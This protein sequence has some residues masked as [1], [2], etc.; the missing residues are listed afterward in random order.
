MKMKEITYLT[1][2]RCLADAW[3]I[4]QNKN[5]LRTSDRCLPDVYSRTSGRPSS[6]VNFTIGLGVRSW[7]TVNFPVQLRVRRQHFGNLQTQCKVGGLGK[8]IIAVNYKMTTSSRPD[9][10]S[11][12]TI[13]R[14]FTRSGS[15]NVSVSSPL[16]STERLSPS[17][18]RS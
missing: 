17:E 2:G 8:I 15:T 12:S 9:M 11:T 1:S 3:E 5:A 6:S 7:L 14:N 10:K 4:Y 13:F 16:A 18:A